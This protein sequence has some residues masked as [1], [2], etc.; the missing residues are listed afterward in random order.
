MKTTETVERDLTPD[1]CFEQAAQAL[2]DRDT[3]RAH[4]WRMLGESIASYQ[5][6]V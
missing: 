3:D 6:A 5:R 2:S 4:H 1:Y